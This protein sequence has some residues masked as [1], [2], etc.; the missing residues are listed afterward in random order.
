MDSHPPLNTM[1]IS[2]LATVTG[3]QSYRDRQSDCS[4]E[5]FREA[6]GLVISSIGLGTYLGS[7]DD[8]TDAQVTEAVVQAVQ[9]GINLIDTA[10]NYRYQHGERSV[11][12]G[13][14]QLINQGIVSREEIVVCT[15]GGFIPHP[16]RA[17]WFRKTYLE[18]S[19]FNL[20]P[21]DFVAQCH[22]MHP[23]YLR[24]Q[25]DRSLSNLGLASVDI[26]YV[27]NPETQRAELSADEFYK[28]LYDAFEFLEGAVAAGKIG[29]Y[30]LA[31]WN[32]FRVPPDDPNH[33]DLARIQAIAKS[34]AQG[35]DSHLQYIQLPL[36]LAMPQ[37]LLNA[38]QAVDGKLLPAIEAA[39]RLGIQAIASASI[40]QAQILD[41]LPDE[42]VEILGK[43]LT[44]KAQAALQF[45]RSA[46]GVLSALVGMKTPQHVAE[47]L[48]LTKLPLTER[49]YLREILGQIAGL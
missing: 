33:L 22:C 39:H 9:Q 4:T 3:T 48:E 23:A 30:G 45:T 40:A 13:I 1:P 31:T 17:Q 37:A 34:A 11:G 41:K 28:K 26:Y 6:N 20:Q 10:I 46:P 36:N 32:G 38:T 7:P 29:A 25:L 27:H 18:S 47:N 24:D 21:E 5:H 15:K 44:S 12:A 16:D 14:Q 49:Y 42:F 19:D 43:T 8:K 2:G 35:G